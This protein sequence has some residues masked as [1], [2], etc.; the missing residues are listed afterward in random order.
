MSADTAVLAGGE[1]EP[2]NTTT[3]NLGRRLGTLGLALLLAL[4]FAG[5][6][7][8]AATVPGRRLRPGPAGDPRAEGPTQRRPRARQ[9]GLDGVD[10][11][12]ATPAPTGAITRASKMFQAKAVLNQV[13]ADNQDKVNFMMS[14]Y[15]QEGSGFDSGYAGAG[16]RRFQ[17]TAHHRGPDP[18]GSRGH[19]GPG[20]PVLAGHPRDLQPDPLPGEH[21]RRLRRVLRGRPG[22]VLPDGLGPGDRPHDG[23]ERRQLQPGPRR[24]PRTPTPSRTTPAT[25]SSRSARTVQRFFEMLWS[26]ATNSIRGALGVTWG[27]TGSG[28]GPFKSG[29]PYSLLF[30]S[31]TTSNWPGVTGAMGMTRSFTEDAVSDVLPGG[32]GA[33]VERRDPERS[34]PTGRSA[35]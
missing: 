17:Y 23:H 21:R 33:L 7:G 3:R 30:M 12:R 24:H 13:I 35:A 31:T 18:A 10:A 27:D 32:C 19:G 5:D 8:R 20:L 26:T 25:G 1:R 15:Q 9:L 4:A 6:R 14:Q 34:R 2:M 16:V 29:T 11:R 22:P 28:G